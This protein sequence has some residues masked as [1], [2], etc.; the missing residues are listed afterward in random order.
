MAEIG[1]KNGM[2][3]GLKTQI[4]GE[5]TKEITFAENLPEKHV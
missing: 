1:G 5:L 4:I 3:S 2:V